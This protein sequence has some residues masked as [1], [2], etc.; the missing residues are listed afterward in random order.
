MRNDLTDITLVVDRSGSMQACRDDAEG[1]INAFIQEQARAPGEVLLTLVEFSDTWR[2]LFTG[3]PI[4]EVEAYRFRPSGVTALHDALCVAIN[5]TGERLSVMPESERPACV[6]FVV[7]TDGQENAST[8]YTL[9]DV[10]TM[11][12]QQ[13]SRY[14]WKFTFLGV[15][16]E[17]FT[18]GQQMGFSRDAI[19]SYDPKNTGVAYRAASHSVLSCRSAALAGKD[20]P[21][22]YGKEQREAMVA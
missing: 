5:K 21:I 12:E 7:V 17:A 18:D 16:P 19:A 13:Q 22:G 15:G 11:I 14:S 8:E 4:K 6:V 10:R 20:V 3:K 1:G 9:V 2:F